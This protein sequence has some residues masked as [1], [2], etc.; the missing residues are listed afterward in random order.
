M[1]VTLKLFDAMVAIGLK[2]DVGTYN[3]VLDA[4]LLY[5]LEI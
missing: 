4:M 3:T 1:D 2:P 5:W